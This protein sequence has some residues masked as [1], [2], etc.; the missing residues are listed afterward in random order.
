MNITY[1]ETKQCCLYHFKC[2]V[3]MNFKVYSNCFNKDNNNNIFIKDEYRTILKDLIY[4]DVLEVIDKYIIMGS[5]YT[6]DWKLTDYQYLLL[7]MMK[8]HFKTL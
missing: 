8:E 7:D 3:L 2:K 1:H 4:K 6:H 5:D